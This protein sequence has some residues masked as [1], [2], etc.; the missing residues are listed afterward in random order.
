MPDTPSLEPEAAKAV[1]NGVLISVDAATCW[2]NYSM[3]NGPSFNVELV[4]VSAV[5]SSVPMTQ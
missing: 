1:S 3:E 5:Q 2:S 4:R